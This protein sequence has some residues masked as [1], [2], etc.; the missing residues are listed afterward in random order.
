MSTERLLVLAAFACSGRLL[1][2]LG[3][4]ALRNWR[5]YAGTGQRRQKDATG[6]APLQPV[7]TADR[8][9]LLGGLGYQA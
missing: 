8:A 6:R 7:G 2:H 9:A 1:L 4:A 3:P 5:I